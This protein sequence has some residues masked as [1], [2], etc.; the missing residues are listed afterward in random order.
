MLE[1]VPKS[2]MVHLP[3][4]PV[5]DQQP[6]GVTRMQRMLGDQAA[7]QFVVEVVRPQDRPLARRAS[8]SVFSVSQPTD[9]HVAA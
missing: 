3:A 7:R 2:P 6:T 9:I 8:T 1:D 5:Y 4:R